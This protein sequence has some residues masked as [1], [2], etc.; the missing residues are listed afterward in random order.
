MRLITIKTRQLLYLP[1][2]ILLLVSFSHAAAPTKKFEAGKKAKVTGTIVSRNGDLV[3][4]KVKKESTSAIVN[5]TDDTKIEREK[6]FRLRKAHMDVT[7]MLPGLTISVEGVGNSKGQLDAGKITFNPDTFAVEVAE[8]QQIEANKSAA[9]NAQATANQ[10]V[11][12][13]GQ[14]QASANQAGQLAAA[15]GAGAVMDAEAISLVNKRVSNLGDYQTVVEAALFFDPDQSTL[16]AADKKALDKLATDAMSTQNYMIEIAG[17]ASST[18]TKAQN[19]KLSDERATAVAD[20]LRNSANVPMRRILTPAGYG[21][22]HAAAPNSDPEGRDI[23]RRVD[24]KVLV[25]KGLDQAI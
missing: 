17:Y 2:L 21:A 11:S 23:N 18:G 25:N 7:A 19:Q 8:E 16:S 9:A 20:Y 24:V 6:S 12:A 14:A 15:A 13:A 3:T 1:A 5:I 10:G 4:V 22:T